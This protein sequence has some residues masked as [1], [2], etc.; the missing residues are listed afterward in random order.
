MSSGS[1]SSDTASNEDKCDSPTPSQASAAT[2][3]RGDQA[4]GGPSKRAG[5]GRA[6]AVGRARHNKPK[7]EIRAGS[8]SSSSQG[9]SKCE[10]ADK[11]PI[12]QVLSAILYHTFRCTILL[13]YF[14]VLCALQGILEVSAPA[15][16]PVATGELPALKSEV[17]RLSLELAEAKKQVTQLREKEGGL[18]EQLN[19]ERKKKQV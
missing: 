1:G 3:V 16:A 9:C 15:P 6:T 12:Y 4:G 7:K 11:E 5:A 8:S 18:K 10:G 19:Q 17:S 2:V 14:T 13:Q